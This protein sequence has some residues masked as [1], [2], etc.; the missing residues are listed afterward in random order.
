MDIEKVKKDLI[1]SLDRGNQKGATSHP[2]LLNKLVEKDDITHEFTLPITQ[3]TTT[4]IVGDCCTPLLFRTNRP[5]MNNV[6]K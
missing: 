2:I 4:K 1:V 6:N 5:Y 3:D